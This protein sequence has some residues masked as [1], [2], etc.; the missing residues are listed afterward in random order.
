MIQKRK[1]HRVTVALIAILAGLTVYG[2]GV[3]LPAATAG[4]HSARRGHATRSLRATDTAHLRYVSAAGSLLVEV[5]RASGTLPGRM[6]VRLR[7]T[8]TFSGSFT[9]Y[10]RG[11]S[12]T[13]HGSASPHGSGVWESFAGTLAVTGGSG[14]FKHAGGR[15]GLYGTFNRRTYALVVQTTGTLYY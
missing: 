5:G 6:H 7:V 13:G 14:R 4:A 12:I 8:T 15:A 3:W 9:I 2:L 1:Q 11:G 10:T